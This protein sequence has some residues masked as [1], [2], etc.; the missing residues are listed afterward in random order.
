MMKLLIALLFCIPV[1]ASVSKAKSDMKNLALF[2]GRVSSFSKEAKLLRFKINFENVKF[3][4]KG[5]VVEFW[6]QQQDVNKCKGKVIGR[7]SDYLLLKVR[8]FHRCNEIA[9]FAIG[10]YFKIE[11]ID[12]RT[13][14]STARKLT[15]ILLKKRLALQSKISRNDKLIA[16]YLQRVEATNNRY[17]I[18]RRKLEAEWRDE[19]TRLEE[20]HI[21]IVRNNDGLKIRLNETNHKLEVYQVQDANLRKDRWSL[22]PNLY[23][24][25]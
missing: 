25:K 10:R 20:D 2:S 6:G 22:D 19:L 4:N 11:S 15:E 1:L 21:E 23:I 8:A 17:E 5:D 9:P 13:N 14:I 18:L 3:L 12:L 7:S 24:T 16:T